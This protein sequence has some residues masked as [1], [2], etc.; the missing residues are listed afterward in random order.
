MRRTGANLGLFIAAVILASA[1]VAAT[2]VTVVAQGPVQRFFDRINTPAAP[3]ETEVA[4]A[5]TPTVAAQPA[6]G[7]P[8]AKNEDALTLLVVG[9]FMAS[10]LARGLETTYAAEPRL[11]V[12]DRT[13]GSSGIVR[14][15]FYDWIAQLPRILAE[16]TPDF[17][18][19]MI[20]TNDRQ[21]MRTADGTERLRSPGWD[22]EYA[23]RASAIAAILE[24]HGKPALWVGQPPMRQRTMSTD[25]A[26]FNSVYEAAIEAIDGIYVDVWD[27][28]ADVEGRFT[29]T[30]P[31]I[32]G[33]N[34]TL[35][36][37]D[38]FSLT[39]AGRVKL[40]YYVDREIRL[41]GPGDAVVFLADPEPGIRPEVLPDGTRQLVG[42][43]IAFAQPPPGAPT[44][45]LDRPPVV[46]SGTA[47][48]R[49]LVRG[50]SLLPVT[51][52]ADDFRWPRPQLSIPAAP[53]VLPPPPAAPEATP[54]P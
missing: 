42:P 45:L 26:F 10:G 17:V 3:G 37:E 27:A 46:V 12:I 44:E 13:N 48:Y 29:A 35:R 9:D 36:G 33:R 53:V 7:G 40:A 20:G 31:D 32:D 23:A 43:V 25:M 34:R 28:F 22:A 54:A 4:Q 14:A 11:V 21:D 24:E 2:T 8:V 19:L 39:T 15:D 51:G 47:Q 16:V 1:A 6:R 38:G 5:A 30:G 50:E 49:L 41:P 52:R 18:V